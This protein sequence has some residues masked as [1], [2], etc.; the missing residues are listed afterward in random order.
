LDNVKNELQ[1]YRTDMDL[2]KAEVRTLQVRIE[3][4]FL[5]E[6]ENIFL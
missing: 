2:Y 3:N 4:E 5:R 1:K 6:K